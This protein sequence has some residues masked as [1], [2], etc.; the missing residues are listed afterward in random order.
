M[1]LERQVL[2]LKSLIT[3]KGILPLAVSAPAR[4][5]RVE[6]WADLMAKG[7]VR[8][9]S[10]VNPF[11]AEWCVLPESEKEAARRELRELAP[12]P[13]ATEIIHKMRAGWYPEQSEWVTDK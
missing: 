5:N 9:P 11:V 6:I 8:W 3:Q 13:T 7:I 4:H 10:A 2:S 12:V 1:Q